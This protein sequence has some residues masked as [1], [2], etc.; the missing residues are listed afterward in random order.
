[1][2]ELKVN[3]ISE[4]TGA[5]GVVVDSV[6]LKDGG[7]IIADA[8]N[9]GSASDTDAIAIASGGGVTFSQ[10]A[11]FSSTI[12]SGNITSTGTVQGTTITATTAFVPDASDGAALGTT[13]LEF[14]DLFLAD[15]AVIGL[16]DDQEVTLTHVADT[17]LTLN[18]TNKLMFNDASQFIQGTSATVLSIG[19]TDE[20][21]LTAT[22]V[23][24]NGTLNVSG[25]ATFQA[26]PVFPDG[27]LA[28]ADLDIDGGTDIG[29]AI[30]DADL[31]IVDDGAGGTNRKATA[32]RLKTYMGGDNTPSFFAFMNGNQVLSNN[33]YTKLEMDAEV[34]DTDS[35][36]NVSN[37]RF[38]PT[39]AGYYI[40]GV[41]FRID[42]GDDGT[43]TR[44]AIYKNGS[45]YH[46]DVAG[47]VDVTTRKI[48][49]IVYL[50][51]DDYVEAYGYQNTGGNQT[52]NGN[53]SFDTVC[54]TFYGYRL[55]GV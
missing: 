11:T 15:G 9:I 51:A 43:D 23:D 1:M 45:S 49:Q 20:I 37:Y 40:I 33:S 44:A 6:K 29:A 5:N 30:A 17:G 18:S 38:T 48:V 3:T 53:S 26:A 24:L 14:S 12:G 31:L 52:V 42:S 28:L 47:K 10:A 4:V 39:V 35:T 7:V 27:S 21:D 16:G 34:Y 46:Q 19:A 55:L 2:S 8:G 54:G 36:Y 41:M 32:A 13:A 25:V 22:T 50:D